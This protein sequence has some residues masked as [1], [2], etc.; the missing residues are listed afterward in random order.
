MLISEADGDCPLPIVLTHGFPDSFVRFQKLIPLLADPAAN[1]GDAAFDVVAPSLLGYGLSDA[2]PK[3][4]AIFAAGKICHRLMTDVLGCT[5]YAA[6]GG[7]WAV[8]SSS[9]SGAATPG[10]V[11]GIHL[12][13]VPFW[14]AFRKPDDLSAAETDY[15][16]TLE[17][18][19]MKEGAYAMIQGRLADREVPALERLRRRHRDVLQ[20]GRA[21]DQRH[22]LLGHA[23]HGLV[24]SA[25][26]R[27]HAGGP[28][29]LDRR[30]VKGEARSNDTPAGFAMFPKDLSRPPRAWAERF[31]NVVRWT[32]MPA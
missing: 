14:H 2:S 4:D 28:P 11:V 6:H 17:E 1:G 30:G 25:P 15:V 20:Q 19:Q 31:F 26:L 23:D 32:A 13:D 16:Q 24:V 12:T 27:R 8:P 9:R 18:F 10:F 7:D 22:D 29:A 5:R 21:A 3:V